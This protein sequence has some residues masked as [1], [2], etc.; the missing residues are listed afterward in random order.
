MARMLNPGDSL[1]ATATVAPES[2][3]C[4]AR[5]TGR[6]RSQRTFLVGSLVLLLLLLPL[7]PSFER[8]G[9][10][11]DEG[12]LLLYTEIIQHC[13]VPF[14]DLE[15]LYGL[16]NNYFLVANYSFFCA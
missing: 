7:I 3:N 6:K 16:S 4:L 15:T 14:R 5:D 12:S 11:M 2:S 13:M 1:V 10:P 9:S 8:G